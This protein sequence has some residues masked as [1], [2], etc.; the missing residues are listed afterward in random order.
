MWLH[1]RNDSEFR[2]YKYEE[3]W[4]DRVY[5]CHYS[6][7][8]VNIQMKF[9]IMT[10]ISDRCFLLN[11]LLFYL[12]CFAQLSHGRIH[13]INFNF[14]INFRCSRSLTLSLISFL[15]VCL[16]K[17]RHNEIDVIAPFSMR[18]LLLILAYLCH[19]SSHKSSKFYACNWNEVKK[20]RKRYQLEIV[21]K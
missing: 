14:N 10:N 19:R 4:G 12:L 5:V 11:Q 17:C 6:S 20:R 1:N 9:Y 16:L 18:L 8:D 15:S 13:C 21:M 7:K 2:Q 3:Q